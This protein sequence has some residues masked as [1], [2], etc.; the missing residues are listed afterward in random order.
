MNVA[1]YVYVLTAC[2][3]FVSSTMLMAL[4]FTPVRWWL[5]AC[6]MV[7]ALGLFAGA[8][9]SYL[10]IEGWPAEATLPAKFVYVSSVIRE[11]NQSDPG[12]ITLWVRPEIGGK[13]ADEPRSYR[14]PYSQDEHAK[15]A[16]MEKDKR[17]AG[18]DTVDVRTRNDQSIWLRNGSNRQYE[19]DVRRPNQFL[20]P[21][22]T[23]PVR[24]E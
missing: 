14:I 9:W 15:V 13:F 1:S 21:K 17:E 8:Y 19:F 3:V 18:G 2:F 7:I 22:T 12:S 11:P 23:K 20:P 24:T 16:E 4:I 10:Q 6:L 5:K